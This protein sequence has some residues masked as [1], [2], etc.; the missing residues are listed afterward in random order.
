MYFFYKQI[1]INTIL[2]FHCYYFK[3][4]SFSSLICCWSN[5]LLFLRLL[6]SFQYWMRYFI[7]SFIIWLRYLLYPPCIPLRF[8]ICTVNQQN[9]SIRISSCHSPIEYLYPITDVVTFQS[10]F[11]LIL[12]YR[13]SRRIFL[14]FIYL[15]MVCKYKI[16]IFLWQ[17]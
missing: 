12:F 3:F 9:S 15:Y 11:T 5:V 14:I 10:I 6:R 13:L 7:S 2:L 1:R 4:I 16:Y 8:N 17:V